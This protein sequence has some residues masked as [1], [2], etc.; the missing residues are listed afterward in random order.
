MDECTYQQ[1]N[2]NRETRRD[3]NFKTRAQ[4]QQNEHN[5][6]IVNFL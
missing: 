2:N 5:R 6:Q 3:P 1:R 4:P